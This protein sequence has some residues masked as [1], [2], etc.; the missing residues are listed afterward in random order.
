MGRV[1]ARNASAS[2]TV[3][4]L[5]LSLAS[6]RKVFMLILLPPRPDVCQ[7]CASKHHATDAH[8]GNSLYYQYW[9]RAKH[10]RWPTWADAVAHCEDSVKL[11]WKRVLD[12]RDRWTEP[13]GGKP[14]ADPPEFI[15]A[16]VSVA[17]TLRVRARHR[18]DSSQIQGSSLLSRLFRCRDL[19][20][21]F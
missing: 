9:F 10:G 6:Q 16:E 14:I 21:G 4:A 2:L 12:Q 11:L 18:Q 8:N 7:C 3:G 1:C 20:A 15:E 5:R 19:A 17:V 13:E